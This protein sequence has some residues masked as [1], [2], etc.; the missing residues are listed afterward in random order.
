MLYI[1][2]SHFTLH[3][4]TLHCTVTLHCYTLHYTVTLHCHT[5]HCTV[6]LYTVLSH[7][8]V[9]LYCHTALSHFTLYCSSLPRTGALCGLKQY[10]TLKPRYHQ[11]FLVSFAGQQ[12]LQYSGGKETSGVEVCDLCDNMDTLINMSCVQRTKKNKCKGKGKTKRAGEG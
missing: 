1:A 12:Q 5:L 4:H 3:C 2:L 6:T 7:C 10:S 11:Y 8:T 9:T